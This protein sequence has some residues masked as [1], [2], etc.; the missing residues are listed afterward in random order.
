GFKVSVI[1]D[2]VNLANKSVDVE[3]DLFYL[4]TD[5]KAKDIK[6]AAPDFTYNAQTNP[7]K[8]PY[9]ITFA[10]GDP[11]H[12]EAEF[13]VD[14][15]KLA[16]HPVG[17][18]LTEESKDAAIKK[19]VLKEGVWAVRA[20]IPKHA[21]EVFPDAEHVRER[22]GIQ[23]IQKKLR[24]LLVAGAPGREFQFIR[25]FLVREVQ[26]NRAT[27]TLLVQNEAGTTG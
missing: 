10:P 6:T 8:A 1:A 16:A 15:V 2:A 22:T 18:K 19:P 24:I 27:V 21:D 7:A 20:R 4:G 23:V 5:G 14:P 12:G 11:P 26:D 9:Q 3:L 13:E 17:A 25:T